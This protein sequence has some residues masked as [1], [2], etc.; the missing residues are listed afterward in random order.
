MGTVTVTVTAPPP[1]ANNA[2]VAMDDTADTDEDESVVINVLANDDDADGDTLTVTMA[3]EPSDGEAVVADDGMSITYTPDADYSGEDQFMYT[4]SDGEAADTA[5]V[6]ITV[7]AAEVVEPGDG[8]GDGDGDT[9]WRWR[10]LYV[11][12]R[13]AF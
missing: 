1:P 2:P 8:D 4:V 12:P 7:E 9:R 3:T 10:G 6:Y 5:T 13:R 11:E